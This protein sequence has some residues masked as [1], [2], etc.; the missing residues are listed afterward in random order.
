MATT[1]RQLELA[2]ALA[3]CTIRRA[4]LLGDTHHVSLRPAGEGHGPTLEVAIERALA[5]ACGVPT[6]CVECGRAVGEPHAPGCFLG[7]D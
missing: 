2:L 3:G 6:H 7:D 5:N 4:H 1:A